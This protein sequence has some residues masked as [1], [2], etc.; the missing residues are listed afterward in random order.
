M[1][2]EDDELPAGEIV[3]EVRCSVCGR[4]GRSRPVDPSSLGSRLLPE[5]ESLPERWTL[6]LG[7]PLMPRCS[8]CQAVAELPSWPR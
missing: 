6:V 3:G 8:H 5:F 1:A 4:V 7:E 2:P